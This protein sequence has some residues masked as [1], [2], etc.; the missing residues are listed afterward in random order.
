MSEIEGKPKIYAENSK[1]NR[2]LKQKKTSI[3]IHNRNESLTYKND[4]LEYAMGIAA[5]FQNET[6][7]ISIGNTLNML[8]NVD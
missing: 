5:M 6:V 4:A 3:V 8:H 2:E 7:D 1:E